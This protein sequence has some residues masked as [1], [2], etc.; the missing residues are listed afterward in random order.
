VYE[1][2]CNEVIGPWLMILDNADDESFLFRQAPDL[3]IQG[4]SSRGGTG[5][6]SRFLPQALHGSILVTPRNQLVAFKLV[7]NYHNIIK[8]NQMSEKDMLKAKFSVDPSMEDDAKRLLKE[9]GYIPLAITQAAAY[10]N[11]RMTRMTI[12]KYLAV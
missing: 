5:P 12:T 6:L 1:A 8:V 11:S 7:G 4:Q 3:S 10:I 9:L 2:L